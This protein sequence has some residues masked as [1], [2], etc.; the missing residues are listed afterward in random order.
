MCQFTNESTALPGPLLS[1]VFYISGGSVR[2]WIHP[3]RSSSKI[4]EKVWPLG[5]YFEPGKNSNLKK[6]YL[7]YNSVFSLR[8]G[9]YQIRLGKATSTNKVFLSL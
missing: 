5:Y 7:V 8:Y 1:I 4:P 6:N 9:I 3:C 2:F